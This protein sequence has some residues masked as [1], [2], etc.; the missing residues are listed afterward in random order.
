VGRILD[1]YILDVSYNLALDESILRLHPNNDYLMTLRF[2]RNPRSVIIG[3]GQQVREEIVFDYCK[4]H[5]IDIARRISGGGAVYHDLG[6]LNTSI[7]VPKKRLEKPNDITHVSRF[8]SEFFVKSLQE[9][10]LEVKCIDNTNIM[11]DDK[12]ISGA[13]SYFTRGW[14]LYHATLLHSAD[15]N[16]LELSLV[17]NKGIRKRKSRYRP[18]TNLDML[19]VDQWK[20]VLTKI[21]GEGFNVEF[22]HQESSREE[23][24]LATRLRERV[25][26]NRDWIYNGRRTR[27]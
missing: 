26:D 1:N 4:I 19:D 3:R 23:L 24:E 27:N 5:S 22:V 15:L 25:Y 16:H 7:F 18:T 14:V 20:R 8:F 12:K 13:A 2:W 10:G 9:F 11:Y 6:N 17:H 21:L